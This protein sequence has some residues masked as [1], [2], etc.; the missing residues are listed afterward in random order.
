MA[1][2]L[3][4][5]LLLAPTCHAFFSA[6]GRPPAPAAGA[7]RPSEL[8]DDYLETM[9]SLKGMTVAITGASRG[10]GFVTAV[11]VARKG[12]RVLML[13]RPSPRAAA[14]LEEVAAAATDAAPT[15][16]DY[17]ALDL[18]SVSSAAAA[19]QKEV[20]EGGLDVLCC[21]AGIM[22]QV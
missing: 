20:A 13:N 11:S 16:I 12:G 15:A 3:A 2:L 22:L 5:S 18:A 17:D 8:Y 4:A 7:P 14:A 21:N 10:L 1:R 19:I 6:F 9:P